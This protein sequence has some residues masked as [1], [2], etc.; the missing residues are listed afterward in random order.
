MNMESANPAK[1]FALIALAA[2]LVEEIVISLTFPPG[3]RV[4]FLSTSPHRDYLRRS[5]VL[6]PAPGDRISGRETGLAFAGAGGAPR[7]SRRLS[8]RRIH[9]IGPA[10]MDYG[11]G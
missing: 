4:A 7:K 2:L 3:S 9:Q 8:A 6:G 5:G 11:L 10:R 1:R